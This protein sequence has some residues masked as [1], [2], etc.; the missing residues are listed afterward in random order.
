MAKNIW[1]LIRKKFGCHIHDIQSD[2]HKHICGEYKYYHY[3][4]VL[5]YVHNPRCLKRHGKTTMTMV[6]FIYNFYLI[7]LQPVACDSL[8][9]DLLGLYIIGEQNNDS[10]CVFHYNSADSSRFGWNSVTLTK[11]EQLA[12]G[13]GNP[14]QCKIYLL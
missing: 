10:P 5:V 11:F 14:P 6:Y 12:K 1:H 13:W 3:L 7:L 8:K 4:C 2:K 9:N